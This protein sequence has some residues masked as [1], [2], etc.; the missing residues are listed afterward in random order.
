M[1]L[2]TFER[3]IHPSYHKELTASKNTVKA[4]LP[5]TVFIPLQQHAGARC[6]PL[7]KK[8]DVVVEGQ[9][10][11]DV[12]AFVSAPVHASINGKVKDIDYVNHP[13]AGR[14]LGVIIDGDGTEKD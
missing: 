11:G 7:V 12:K 4:L 13:S 10:L 3:G 2:K 1:G 6:E 5:K 14:T 9:K 8:G